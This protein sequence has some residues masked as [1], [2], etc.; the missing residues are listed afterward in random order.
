MQIEDSLHLDHHS[1][2]PVEPGKEKGKPSESDALV[3]EE[4]EG[5]V[6]DFT[7]VDD[8]KESGAKRNELAQVIH[9]QVEPDPAAVVGNEVSC[10]LV[11]HGVLVILNVLFLLE[12]ADD[13]RSSD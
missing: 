7:F 9:T 5:S 10:D 12:S 4:A 6:V 2:E 1:L 11:D 3:E 13:L 8:A